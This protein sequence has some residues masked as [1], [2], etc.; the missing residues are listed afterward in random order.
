MSV[1]QGQASPPIGWYQIILLGN[2][3][4]CVLLPKGCIRLRVD[5]D[6]NPRPVDCRSS[7]LTTQP[8]ATPARLEFKSWF[9]HLSEVD[10]LQD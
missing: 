3:G 1:T 6:S 4:T 7:I 8:Q 2:K 10:L 5:Q 9:S